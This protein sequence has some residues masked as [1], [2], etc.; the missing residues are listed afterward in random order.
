M[1]GFVLGLDEDD[2]DVIS[3]RDCGAVQGNCQSEDT[4]LR[5]GNVVRPEEEVPPGMWS[6]SRTSRTMRWR[7]TSPCTCTS[8]CKLKKLLYYFY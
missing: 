4:G 3:Y 5:A 8:L 7:S 1:S 2:G 6:I